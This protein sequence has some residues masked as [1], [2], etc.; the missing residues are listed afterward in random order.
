MPAPRFLRCKECERVSCEEKKRFHANCRLQVITQ[1]SRLLCKSI[2]HTY[3]DDNVIKSKVN[4]VTALLMNI[5]SAYDSPKARESI[6]RRHETLMTDLLYDGAK[7]MLW[8]K[9]FTRNAKKIYLMKRRR[10]SFGE[11]LPLPSFH[12][13]GFHQQKRMTWKAHSENLNDLLACWDWCKMQH[14]FIILSTKT[15]PNYNT[16]G[17]MEAIYAPDNT[18]I[19]NKERM[20]RSECSFV[21]DLKCSAIVIIMNDKSRSHISATSNK[22]IQNRRWLLSVSKTQRETKIT[23]LLWWP[24]MAAFHFAFLSNGRVHVNLEI[25]RNV[26]RQLF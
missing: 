24:L 14:F 15:A 8:A 6:Q 20:P 10:R 22:P 7:L 4:S 25:S 1:Y 12:V 19:C 16:Q 13:S 11:S 26:H 2:A 23:R 17:Y 3:F 21:V 9:M 5:I 18:Q